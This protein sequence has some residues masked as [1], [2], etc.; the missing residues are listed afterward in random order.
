MINYDGIRIGVEYPCF[1]I[2]EIAQA[3]DGSL[4][5][6]HA[7]IDAV[8]KTGADAIKFQTHIAEYESSVFEPWRVKFSYQDNTRCDYW[9]RMEFTFEQW[10]G[11]KN[12]AEEKGLIFISSPFSVE[13]VEFLDKIGMKIWK[14]A[15]GEVKSTYLLDAM[16][17]T[18]KPIILSSGMNFEN[19]IDRVIKYIENNNII[20]GLMQCTSEY[21]SKPE[22]IGVKQIP[23]LREKYGC[24]IG[25][26]D[27]SGTIYSSLAAVTLGANM[28]EVH[29]TM[30]KEM[31]GPDVS[32]SVTTQEF[33]NLVEGVR[34]IERMMKSEEC[35]D[36][37]TN[38]MSK[39]RKIFNK[40]IMAKH[41]IRLGTKLSIQD[42]NFVKPALGIPANEY[43]DI[44]GKKA[45]I[46]IRAKQFITKEMLE[47]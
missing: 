44:L 9:K 18:K 46:D 12:H 22:H 24:P 21:P 31:F 40:G 38:S 25:L 29:I 30:S 11:L 43:K 26:S 16:I 35:K 27:H 41:D 47:D 33:V 13:A 1:V 45:V 15:S 3:H 7:Y 23:I 14:V 42:M 5:M 4:G 32:S 2:A 39:L 6:A 34:F 19:E 36:Q 28:V 8:A 10:I 37:I 17:K 20:Y